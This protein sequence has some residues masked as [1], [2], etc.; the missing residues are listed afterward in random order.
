[1]SYV[2]DR[3]CGHDLEMSETPKAEA[4]CRS[5]INNLNRTIR[6]TAIAIDKGGR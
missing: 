1:M 4:L 2:D 5:K 6:E 3:F